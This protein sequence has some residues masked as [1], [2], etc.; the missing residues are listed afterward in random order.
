MNAQH[1]HQSCHDAMYQ[2]PQFRGYDDQDFI[3]Y[4][5]FDD[6]PK[7][8]ILKTIQFWREYGDLLWESGYENALPDD[9]RDLFDNIDRVINTAIK[10][11]C[12]TL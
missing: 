4:G 10:D 12:K 9:V 3:N 1:I 5:N 11:Y 8:G 2:C 6:I 7:L